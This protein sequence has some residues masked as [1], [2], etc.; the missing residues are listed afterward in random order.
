MLSCVIM[1]FKDDLFSLDSFL[2][3]RISTMHMDILALLV[4]MCTCLTKLVFS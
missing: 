3:V 4:V 2:F 1:I